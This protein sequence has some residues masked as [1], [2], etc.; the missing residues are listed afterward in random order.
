MS[1][2]AAPQA[3]DETSVFIVEPNGW[4]GV[5][6]LRAPNVRRNA[7]E[8]AI[9]SGDYDRWIPRLLDDEMAIWI[10]CVPVMQCWHSVT[11]PHIAR[12]EYALAMLSSLAPTKPA[13]VFGPVVFTGQGD[14]RGMAVGLQAQQLE[15][16][17]A[18][19]RLAQRKL[20]VRD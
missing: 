11:K 4:Y 12:N 17:V 20:M 2:P 6:S 15:P 8:A 16:V 13:D 19:Y 9:T 10:S 1:H 3:P 14:E 18:A 7:T 5:L